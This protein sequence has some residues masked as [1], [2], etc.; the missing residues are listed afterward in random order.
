MNPF[1]PAKWLGQ[2]FLQDKDILKRI[3]ESCALEP[4]EDVV[5]IGPGHGALTREIVPRVRT[6][7]AVEMDSR[8]AEELHQELVPKGLV[9]HHADILSLDL[10]ALVSQPVKV[11]GNIPYNISTPIVE[12]MVR[13]KA[14]V[15]SLY[16]TVQYE[17]AKR[18]IAP[19]G[20]RDRSALTCLLEFFADT[21]ILFRISNRSF[22]PI[23]TVES[24]FLRID[25]RRTPLV[26]LKDEAHFLMLVKSAFGQR[27]KM[28]TNALQSR[29]P[30]ERLFA[31]LDQ[32]G[33]KRN[34]RPED[35]CS[36]DYAVLSNYLCEA[37]Q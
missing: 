34:A 19:V 24:C 11:I 8:L 31:A 5:E 37:D 35:L 12:K 10:A 28:L 1:R 9:L 33:V 23:P 26:V 13:E 20:T 7:I 18:L 3:I 6:V 32:A 29:F 17:F 4:T 25:F 16:L 14:L 30:R 15:S 27:R 36:K 2:N 21:R 22:R